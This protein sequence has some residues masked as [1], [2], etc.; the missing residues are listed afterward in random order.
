MVK[1]ARNHHHRHHRPAFAQG[2]ERGKAL[3]IGDVEIEQDQINIPLGGQRI[4]GPGIIGGL[5]DVA[6]GKTR[7]QHAA[8]AIAHQRM[9]I[10]DQDA[11]GLHGAMVGGNFAR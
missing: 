10:H 7:R 2:F 6:G 8:H 9:I 11:I 1:R 5:K 3:G 4:T